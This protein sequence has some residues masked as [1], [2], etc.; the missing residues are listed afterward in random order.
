LEVKSSGIERRLQ[1]IDR[2]IQIMTGAIVFIVFFASGVQLS[3][4]GY[5]LLGGVSLGVGAAVLIFTAIR[6][7]R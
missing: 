1:Q 5:Q 3:L 2:S 4:F 6:H 7:N